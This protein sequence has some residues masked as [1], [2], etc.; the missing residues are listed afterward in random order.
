M[1]STNVGYKTMTYGGQQHAMCRG[2]NLL[3][4][5]VKHPQRLLLRFLLH[6]YMM[7]QTTSLL[8]CLKQD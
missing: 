7:L 5:L 4:Q 3:T 1:F 6:K 8:A 2:Y